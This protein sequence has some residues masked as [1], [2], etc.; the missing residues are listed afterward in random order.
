MEQAFRILRFHLKKIF[1]LCRIFTSYM[2]LSF[3][4]LALVSIF[5]V[6]QSNLIEWNSGRKLNW[7]DFKASPDP[8]SPNAALTN[9]SINVEFGY[10][11]QGLTYSIKCRFD[12]N[13]SWG[14]VKNNLVLSHEQGH[15]DIAEIHARKLNKELKE[16]KFNSRTVANDVNRI[17]EKVMKQHHAAQQEYDEATDFSRKV[18]KQLEWLKKIEADL[19]SLEAYDYH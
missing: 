8:N 14:R 5:S 2:V 17:Y 6:S 15:F 4:S 18:E 19:K 10:S 16:Y 1:N 7:S 12:K 3:F 13:K 9:T 11:K